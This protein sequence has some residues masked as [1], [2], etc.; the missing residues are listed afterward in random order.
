LALLEAGVSL[1]LMRG[2]KCGS[3]ARHGSVEEA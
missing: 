3:A 1:E 2:A